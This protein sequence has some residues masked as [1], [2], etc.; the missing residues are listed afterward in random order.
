MSLTR[1]RYKALW[2][3]NEVSS[4]CLTVSFD[5]IIFAG[6]VLIRRAVIHFVE[7]KIPM[8]SRWEVLAVHLL[9]KMRPPSF[10]HF[11]WR[12]RCGGP[13]PPPFYTVAVFTDGFRANN[14]WQ[15]VFQLKHSEPLRAFQSFLLW[16]KNVHLPG[17]WR[18]LTCPLQG[19]DSN[20]VILLPFSTLCS[21]H[22]CSQILVPFSVSCGFFIWAI[23]CAFSGLGW[24]ILQWDFLKNAG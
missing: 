12:G 14:T 6:R 18:A 15:C 21:K 13:G 1:G 7:T 23:L 24:N 16:E 8:E 2:S 4:C 10:V 5:K 3:G 19:C 17:E 20:D 11:L 9:N 22:P